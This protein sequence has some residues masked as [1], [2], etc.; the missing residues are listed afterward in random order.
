MAGAQVP[1]TRRER[2]R[3]DRAVDRPGQRPLAGHLQ[4]E[5]HDRVRP[6]R[7]GP[8]RGPGQPPPR[9]RVARRGATRRP[10]QC[11][12]L[13][14]PRGGHGRCRPGRAARGQP[15]RRRPSGTA[16]QARAVRQHRARRRRQLPPGARGRLRRPRHRP[17]HPATRPAVARAP[18]PVL[19]RPGRL[20]GAHLA[21]GRPAADVPPLRHGAAAG[22]RHHAGL[23]RRAG[24]QP[25]HVG[26]PH[27]FRTSTRRRLRHP[28]VAATAHL[29]V[30]AGPAGPFRARACRGRRGEPAGRP[31]QR[32]HLRRPRRR[33]PVRHP[34]RPGRQLVLQAQPGRRP[35]RRGGTGLTGTR[36]RAHRRRAAATRPRWRRQPRAGV[37]ATGPARLLRA[38]GRRRLVGVHRVRPAAHA[39]PHRR[40]PPLGRPQRRRSR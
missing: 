16:A 36:A 30:H 10:R 14:L 29:R 39:R 13:R 26:D 20:R 12:V 25:G 33:G 21:P 2:L 24:R 15:D 22:R 31:R 3:P 37:L 7:R 18:R 5:L 17:A 11:R 28:G 19:H 32:L 38:D 34:D 40:P 27:R 9:L 4:D 35:V 23:P 6:Q 8:G 1:A